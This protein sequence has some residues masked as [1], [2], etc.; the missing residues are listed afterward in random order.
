MRSDVLLRNNSDRSNSIKKDLLDESHSNELTSAFLSSPTSSMSSIS[1]PSSSVS[2]HSPLVHS[3]PPISPSLSAS[4]ARSSNPPPDLEVTNTKSS[5]SFLGGSFES[6][7]NQYY[8]LTMPKTSLNSFSEVFTENNF[9]LSPQN[10]EDDIVQDLSVKK[11]SSPMSTSN[12]TFDKKLNK[13]PSSKDT[14]KIAILPKESVMNKTKSKSI[15]E[16]YQQTTNHSKRGVLP[17]QATSIMRSW[18]FQH[19]VVSA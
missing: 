8:R 18:L 10:I 14:E 15:V 11:K 2:C 12:E 6:D 13:S 4:S 17:K 19:I 1:S 7:I 3:S 5:P 9:K 16:K